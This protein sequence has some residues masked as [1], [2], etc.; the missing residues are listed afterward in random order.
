MQVRAAVH[1]RE[2]PT[3]QARYETIAPACAGGHEGI[4]YTK[5]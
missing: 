3:A 4:P 5:H 2:A 1:A